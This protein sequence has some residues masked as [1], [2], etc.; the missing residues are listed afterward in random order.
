MRIKLLAIV[1][2]LAGGAVAVAYS[3]GIVSFGSAAAATTTYLTAVAAVSDVSSDIAATGT[4]A[5][6]QSWTFAF[7]SAPAVAAGSSSSSA[8]SSSSSNSSNA[9]ATVTW[10]VTV[11][12]AAVGQT[13]K[14]G[15]VLAT[16]ATT[17]LDV[18]I[19]DAKRAY[20]T[21]D[22]QL[23]QAQD[24]L[25]NATTTAAT[26]Q[27][28]VGLN[29]AQTAFDRA[30]QS[31]LDLKAE[32]AYASL[33]A[34]GDGVVTAVN[35]AVGQ[36]APSGAAITVA[37]RALEVT[38]SV[39]ESDV[40]LISVGQVASV[41]LSAVNATIQGTVASIAPTGNSSGS[42][43]AVSFAVEIVLQDVP[44]TVRSGMSASVTITTASASNVLA[45]PSRA[46]V[47]TAGNYAVR[48][49]DADNTVTV[50]PVEVGLV[51]STLAEIK[52]GIQA[53]DRVITGTSAQQSTTTTNRGGFGG[54][55]GGGNLGGGNFRQGGGNTVITNP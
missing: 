25:A 33:T 48:I 28:Q 40:P 1:V 37:S 35:V 32:R 46:L 7:G 11:V 5:S 42:N 23:G 4:V 47:G 13:V 14:K 54:G 29:N 17:D 31:L 30:H 36:D 45:V 39:V 6:T 55:L 16:A 2:L 43:G 15:D 10:P 3:T 21:A 22:I 44:A 51:T 38:T 52:S 20:S 50:K 49:L 19:A 26:Q 12:Q 18:Q 41:T 24:Q 27:A 34:P 9:A 53:G 8:S